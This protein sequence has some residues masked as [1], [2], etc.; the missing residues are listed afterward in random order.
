MPVRRLD[1]QPVGGRDAPGPVAT[2]LHNRYWER[3]FEGWHGSPVLYGA[4][5]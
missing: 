5:E 2:A 3:R 1:G 4:S